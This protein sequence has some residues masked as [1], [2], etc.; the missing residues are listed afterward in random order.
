MEYRTGKI[1]RVM[2]IRFD[3]GDDFLHELTDMIKKENILLSVYTGKGRN[4]S[5]ITLE[6]IGV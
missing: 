4:S 3:H 1:G 5:L 2:I 6:K